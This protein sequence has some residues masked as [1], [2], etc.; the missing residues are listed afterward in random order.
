MKNIFNIGYILFTLVLLITKQGFASQIPNVIKL[1]KEVQEMHK[2]YEKRIENLELKLKQIGYN[3]SKNNIINRSNTPSR[4]RV[5][6]NDFNPSIGV[7]LNGKYQSFSQNASEMKGFSVPEEGERGKEGIALD[8]SEIN[9]SSNIDDKFFGSLTAAIVNENGVDKIELEEAFIE[10]RPEL[11]LPI[12]FSLK[13]GRAFWNVGY[14]NEHHTHEDDFADRPL[15]YRIFLNNGFN[16]D[17]IEASY[18]LPTNIF[19]QIGG[20]IFRGDDFPSGTAQG[21]NADNHSLFARIGGDIGM[22]H[23]WR[24]G[25]SKIKSN[26][27]GRS[28]NENT[29]TFIGDSDL[30]IVDLRYDFSPTGNSRNQMITVQGEYFI[31]EEAGTYEDT[32]SNTGKVLFDDSDDSWYGQIIYKFNPRWRLGYRYSRLNTSDTPSGLVGSNLD[33]ENYNP[34]INTAMIDWS[35]SEFSRLRLQYNQDKTVNNQTDNQVI[36]QYVVSLGAHGAHKY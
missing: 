5:F 28:S 4:S 31:R 36:L 24:F 20:G 11:G 26:S 30:F 9:F 35:N 23:N 21:D 2:F 34:Y 12:G 8:E 3:T 10:T 18:I 17:G 6:G 15:S 14:L 1:Q 27:A 13:A 33:A 22:K 7:I 25:L 29:I 32:A 19:M 16:D